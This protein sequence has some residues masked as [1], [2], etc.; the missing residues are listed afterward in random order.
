MKKVAKWK[1]DMN[2][3]TVCGPNSVITWIM[4][5]G[6]LMP[7]NHNFHVVSQWS[8]A[9]CS[10]KRESSSSKNWSQWPNLPLY[11]TNKIHDTFCYT[12]TLAD[13][14][15]ILWLFLEMKYRNIET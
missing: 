11:S 5:K 3:D 8:Y 12:S 2:D 13:Y 4:W 9:P 1:L 14:I 15:E 7:V 6:V 10:I